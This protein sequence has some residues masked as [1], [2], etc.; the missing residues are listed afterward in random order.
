MSAHPFERHF[1][2]F[3]VFVIM[4]SHSISKRL[5]LELWY[6]ICGH[7][8]HAMESLTFVDDVRNLFRAI[9]MPEQ[10]NRF[11]NDNATLVTDD[12]VF[13][14]C[15]SSNTLIITSEFFDTT[16]HA[17]FRIYHTAIKAIGSDIKRL[18]CEGTT[19]L[20]ENVNQGMVQKKDGLDLGTEI[21]L[22]NLEVIILDVTHVKMMGY[23]FNL[24]SN[25]TAVRF[26]SHHKGIHKEAGCVLSGTFENCCQLKTVD[27]GDYTIKAIGSYAFWGCNSLTEIHVPKGL[28]RIE[29]NAFIHCRG[30]QRVTFSDP[31]PWEKDLKVHK[32]AFE[33]ETR[34]AL[35][36]PKKFNTNA[37]KKYYA[38]KYEI[39]TK[40]SPSTA[41]PCGWK[42]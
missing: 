31:E 13:S 17:D 18:V 6:S 40:L 38:R 10:A 3:C 34:R 11:F 22:P 35:K 19:H 24:L 9:G 41:I 42:E 32:D 15:K 33:K 7:L 12:S 14:R 28:R 8:F 23:C 25:L 39:V 2:A 30:M 5:P 1:H 27:F 16:Q 36:I 4:S 37:C 29:S 21:T 26:T 20:I